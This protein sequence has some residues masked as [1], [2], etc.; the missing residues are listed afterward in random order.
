MKPVPDQWQKI[1][2]S[3]V[4]TIEWAIVSGEVDYWRS[5]IGWGVRSPFLGKRTWYVRDVEELVI[6]ARVLLVRRD[7]DA[8][9]DFA[10]PMSFSV[11]RLGG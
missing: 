9:L 6:G 11:G 1:G 7:L 8:V 5:M 3:G 2:Y 10:G 4:F